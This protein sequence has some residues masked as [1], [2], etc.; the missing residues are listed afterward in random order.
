MC[1]TIYIHDFEP[2]SLDREPRHE[3]VFFYSGLLVT[4][5]STA[6]AHPHATRVAV[7]PALFSKMTALLTF[8]YQPRMYLVKARR[9]TIS[10]SWELSTSRT[11]AEVKAE[12]ASVKVTHP[13]K[14]IP[15]WNN[16]PSS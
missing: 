16:N 14:N 12:E 3:K 1:W 5:S 7:Y 2:D 15:N 11:K 4:F 8:E 9:E 6:P 13:K 10:L